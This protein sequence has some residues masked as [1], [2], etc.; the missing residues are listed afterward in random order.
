M[1]RRNPYR[2][3]MARARAR[4]DFLIHLLLF[5]LGLLFLALLS[6]LLGSPGPGTVM[7]F[8]IW[9]AG[10]GLHGLSLTHPLRRLSR[11]LDR[12]ADRSTH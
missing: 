10:L 8:V 7:L 5:V 12:L 6:L 11:W 3:A 2:D 4:R 9:F 1:P